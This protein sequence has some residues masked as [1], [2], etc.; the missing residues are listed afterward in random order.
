MPCTALED[1]RDDYPANIHQRR[2]T[3]AVSAHGLGA[4]VP[5]ES[6]VLDRHPL[7]RPCEVHTPYFPVSVD[8]LVLQLRNREAA[9][10]HRQPSLALH[11][12]LGPFVGE[13]QQLANRDDAS[14]A[15]LLDGRAP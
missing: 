5:V 12:G 2:L 13:R 11:R 4:A 15:G 9:V 10:D 1:D 8:D 14:A 7:I 3:R 6:L